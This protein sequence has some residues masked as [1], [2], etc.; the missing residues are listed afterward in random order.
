MPLKYWDEA[1]STTAY[2]INRTPSRVIGH[3]T[4]IHK[5]CGASPDYNQL[6]IF[7][8]ACWPNLMPYNTCKLAFRSTRCVFLGYS[9]LHKG[10]KFLDVPSGRVY[11]SRDLI[12]YESVFPF[13]KLNPNAGAQLK[14]EIMLLHPTLIPSPTPQENDTWHLVPRKEAKNVIDSKW[15]YKIKRHADGSIDRYK[16]CLVAK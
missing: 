1:F 5:L 13:L 2:L 9:N 6:R 8:C 11:I 16:A 14:N 7:W 12:F 3:D 15:V 4:P 10:Y